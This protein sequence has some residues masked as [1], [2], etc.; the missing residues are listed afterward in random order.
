MIDPLAIA[1]EGFKNKEGDFKP[2]FAA[3]MGFIG[4]SIE[5]I[6]PPPRPPL[7]GGGIWKK[8][9]V[10]GVE[11]EQPNFAIARFKISFGDKTYRKDFKVKNK[12]VISILA[13]LIQ[14]KEDKIT[15][16]GKL[17]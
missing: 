4:I 8:D 10:Y 13:K 6:T 1:T 2:L 9:Y 3:T 14:K 17:L 5:V 12:K 15:V 16:K 11:E 7:T